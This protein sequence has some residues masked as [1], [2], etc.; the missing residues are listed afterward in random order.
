MDWVVGFVTGLGAL[1]G[2][3]TIIERSKKAGVIQ[4]LLTILFPILLFT[5]CLAKDAYIFGCSNLN[6]LIKAAFVDWKVVPLILIVFFAV[7]VV[8]VLANMIKLL[9]E[10]KNK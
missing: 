3:F 9:D 4:L 7:V 5:W 8:F 10:K 2:I 1:T 6:F